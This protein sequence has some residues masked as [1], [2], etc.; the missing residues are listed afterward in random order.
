MSRNKNSITAT[1]DTQAAERL[2][3]AAAITLAT[4]S[5]Y[6]NRT[7]HRVVILLARSPIT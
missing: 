6:L 7:L 3:L 2:N 5:G 1:T 4:K